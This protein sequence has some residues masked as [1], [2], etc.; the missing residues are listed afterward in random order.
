MLKYQLKKGSLKTPIFENGK[1]TEGQTQTANT[2]FEAKHMEN[3]VERN[4][5][6]WVICYGCMQRV[7]KSIKTE[8][9]RRNLFGEQEKKGRE[10]QRER[11]LKIPVESAQPVQATTHFRIY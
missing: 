2:M 8:T 11:L 6:Q 10:T 1:E 4:V 3:R 9:T 7:N 5:H